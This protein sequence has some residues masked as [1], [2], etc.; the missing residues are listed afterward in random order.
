MRIPDALVMQLVSSTRKLSKEQVAYLRAQEASLHKTMQELVILGQIISESELTQLYARELK[1]PY[2]DLDLIPIDF[3]LLQRLPERVARM[4]SVV[5]FSSN[6]DGSYNIAMS[7]APSKKALELISKYLKRPVHMHLASYTS[8]QRW[9][10]QYRVIDS[11]LGPIVRIKRGSHKSVREVMGVTLAN[12]LLKQAIALTATDIHIEPHEHSAHIRLRIDGKL[13]GYHPLSL[14]QYAALTQ[15]LLQDFANLDSAGGVAP[16]EATFTHSLEDKKYKVSIAVL[17]VIDGQ[18]ISL[19][20]QEQT[21]TPR[22]LSDLGLWGPSLSRLEHA[23]A[24]THGLILVAGPGKAGKT[25]T[26]HGLLQEKHSTHISM[27]AIEDTSAYTE[28]YIS[29]V[30]VRQNHGSTYARCLNASLKHDPDV[31]LLQRIQDPETAQA[32]ISAVEKQ[33]LIC[34]GMVATSA[35]ETIHKMGRLGIPPHDIAHS[36]SCVIGQRLVRKLCQ[37]CKIQAPMNDNTT[38]RVAVIMERTPGYTVRDIHAIE[39]AAEAHAIGDSK[40]LMTSAKKVQGV[41]TN[42]P[43]GCENCHGTGY[44][45]QTGIFETMQSSSTLEAAI[46]GNKDTKTLTDIAIK[47]GMIPMSIDGLVKVLRG[48]TSLDEVEHAIQTIY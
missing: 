25:T 22:S 14:T 28:P 18:K 23:L 47:D 29:H 4:H 24:R 6:A 3:N 34:G 27:I 35:P 43:E 9:L 39:K 42:N 48:V 11:Q 7:D 10:N 31:I 33:H 19:S 15:Y 17:P 40:E 37:H 45:G 13:Q 32:I 26:L 2:V 36:L 20:I 41:W 5:L 21:D 1:I 44:S 12:E 38:Q 30:H 8:L 16:K 46:V